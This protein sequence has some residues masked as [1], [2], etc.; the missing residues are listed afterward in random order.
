MVYRMLLLAELQAAQLSLKFPPLPRGPS[1][2]VSKV[3]GSDQL[4]TQ[5]IP[6]MN[7]SSSEIIHSI[8]L[9]ATITIAT[10]W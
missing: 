3:F 7:H 6:I 1:G 2:S 5:I 10:S 4:S 9:L 8:C